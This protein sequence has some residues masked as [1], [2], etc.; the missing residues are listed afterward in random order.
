MLAKLFT[1]TTAASTS[2]R[3]LFSRSDILKSLDKSKVNRKVFIKKELTEN[4]EFFKAFPHMQGVFSIKQGEPGATGAKAEDRVNENMSYQH[5][6]TVGFKDPS[7]KSDATYFD[8]LLHQHNQ[9]MTPK[10]KEV[11]V[12]ENER[13]FVEA[14]LSPEGPS[15]WMSKE[16]LEYVHSQ[17]DRRMQELEDSGLTREE[18]L[19]DRQ[20]EGI[21]LAD[22]PF[23]QFL[24]NS[25][26][27]REMLIKPGEEFTVDRVIEKALR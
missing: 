21:P 1:Q 18:I 8:S 23:F 3:R 6:E 12:R 16:D 27:A 14:Y 26:S 17:L 9:Y 24:K 4:P 2:G 11:A 10:D 13:N 20:G 7:G 5:Q 19:H 15:K 22:D 25:R